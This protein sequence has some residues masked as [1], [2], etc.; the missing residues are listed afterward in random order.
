MGNLKGFN[1]ADYLASGD[2]FDAFKR[3]N[4]V[5][6]EQRA[7]QLLEGILE[8]HFTIE[9]EVVGTHA[10]TNSRLKIDMIVKPVATDEW[11]DPNI[12]IGIELKRHA[13]AFKDTKD[14]CKHAAQCVDYA[15]TDWDCHGFVYILAYP[16]FIPPRAQDAHLL[17]RFFGQMGVGVIEDSESFGAAFLVNEHTMWSEKQGVVEAKRWKLKRKFGSR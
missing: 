15:N 11:A 5:K 3:A 12:S 8:P 1:V 10:P 13:G 17:H 9:K 2:Q 16:S 4:R 6:P 14:Y 7:V